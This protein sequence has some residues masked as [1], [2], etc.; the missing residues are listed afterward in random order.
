MCSCH[1]LVHWAALILRDDSF[2]R[3]VIVEEGRSNW[4]PHTDFCC[5][6]AGSWTFVC[7]CVYPE[8]TGKPALR[9]VMCWSKSHFPLCQSWTCSLSTSVY[10][11]R[12]R[13]VCLF[14]GLRCWT[15]THLAEDEQNTHT[16]GR[17]GVW[18]CGGSSQH[19]LEKN[20]NEIY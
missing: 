4:P 3:I 8:F 18:G 6:D 19:N 1:K 13:F 9:V 20:I 2:F 5:E 11:R 12:W 17:A 14:F 15:S 16:P 10:V 7:V